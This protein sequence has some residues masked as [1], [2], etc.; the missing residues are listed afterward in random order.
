[1]SSREPGRAALIGPG[2]VLAA[3]LVTGLVLIDLFVDEASRTT[4]TRLLTAVV[5]ALAALRVR[6]LVRWILAREE[7]S[8]FDVGPATTPGPDRS[9]FHQLHD[10]VRFSARNRRYFD[11]VAWPRLVGLAQAEMGAAAA[12]LEKPPSRSFGRGPSLA[13]LQKVIAAIEARR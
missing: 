4:L 11:L 1:L 5:L 7:R 12:S 13:A 10:E 6:T 9:R 2:V 8:S 3:L